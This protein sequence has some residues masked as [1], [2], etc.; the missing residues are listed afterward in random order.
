[1]HGNNSQLLAL[2]IDK[3]NFVCMNTVINGRAL[4]L[5]T[6]ALIITLDR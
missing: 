4:F 3:A 2:G 1:L 6:P 5:R